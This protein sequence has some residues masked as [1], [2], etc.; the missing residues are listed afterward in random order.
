MIDLLLKAGAN[1]NLQLKLLPPYRAV[2]ADRGADTLLSIG[3][4][5][6]IRAAKAGD[7]AAIRLLLAHGGNPNLPQAG[8]ITAV[9][10]AAGLGSTNIDTRGSLK[11]QPELID[12]LKLMLAGG[13]DITLRDK[14]GRSALHGAAFWGYNDIV[15][16]LADNK[17]PLDAQDLKGLTPLDYALGKAGGQGRGG[18]G[19][20]VN[21][22]TA[23]LIEEL[24]GSKVTAQR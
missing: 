14:Q 2:G 18:Q 15:R 12:S 11:T 17:A 3:T 13:G 8:G 6:M 22:A 4:T 21:P 10:A 23:K 9:M 24:L 5:P 1:P 7:T 16:F 20:T 19:V